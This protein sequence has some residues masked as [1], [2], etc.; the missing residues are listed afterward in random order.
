LGH[1]AVFLSCHHCGALCHLWS[2][3]V[4]VNCILLFKLW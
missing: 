2:Q 3:L 1:E 4:E